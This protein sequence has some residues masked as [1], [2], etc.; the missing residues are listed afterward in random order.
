MP[1]QRNGRAS[2]VQVKGNSPADSVSAMRKQIHAVAEKV[3][4]KKTADSVS[5]EDLARI[6]KAEKRVQA[7]QNHLA[8][9][10][11][12][13]E[14]AVKNAETE[15]IKAIGW[16]EGVVAEV[17]EAYGMGTSDVVDDEG[18]INRVK[19]EEAEPPAPSAQPGKHI[20]PPN[21]TPTTSPPQD[22]VEETSAPVTAT[23][24]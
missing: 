8:Q 7:T 6:Q 3:V 20:P 11:Q 16:A 17:R 12:N 10:R 15:A 21:D 1:Q 2:T 13:A 19:Q 22:A 23:V 14:M 9:M 5:P 24:A 4:D 18:K